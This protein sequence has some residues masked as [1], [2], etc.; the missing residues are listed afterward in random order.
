MQVTHSISLDSDG[1]AV[2]DAITALVDQLPKIQQAI[3]HTHIT[4]KFMPKV[5]TS[6]MARA[7]ANWVYTV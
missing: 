4:A 3:I 5:P 6:E 7:R 1:Y 2:M